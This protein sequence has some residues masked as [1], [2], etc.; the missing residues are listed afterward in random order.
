M[1]AHFLRSAQY[2][3]PMN[4]RVEEKQFAG[5]QRDDIRRIERDRAIRVN[6]RPSAPVH[7][8]LTTTP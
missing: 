6:R 5:A 1:V 2:A 4:G 7:R 8:S 3:A